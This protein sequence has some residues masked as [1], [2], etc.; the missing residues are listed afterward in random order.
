M[1]T[2]IDVSKHNA[3]TSYRICATIEGGVEILLIME[4]GNR[5]DLYK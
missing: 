1:K 5:G 3:L 2:G 4:I